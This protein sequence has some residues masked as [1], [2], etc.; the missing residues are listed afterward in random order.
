MKGR[1]IHNG[2]LTGNRCTASGLLSRP[3][4]RS[5]YTAQTDQF[6][7]SCS[8]WSLRYKKRDQALR[9]ACSCAWGHTLNGKYNFNSSS[10][11]H[12][13]KVKTQTNVIALTGDLKLST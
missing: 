2:R 11:L 12:V 4:S 9:T 5:C 8:W 10:S 6:F 13:P 1:G 7:P 3:S